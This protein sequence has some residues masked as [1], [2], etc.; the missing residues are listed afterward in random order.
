MSGEDLCKAD[1]NQ[2]AFS[3]VLPKPALTKFICKVW[4]RLSCSSGPLRKLTVEL[5]LRVVYSPSTGAFSIVGICAG[6]AGQEAGRHAP[7][8]R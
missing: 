3:T 5:F 6:P 7:L 8:W 4:Q 2:S 1:C